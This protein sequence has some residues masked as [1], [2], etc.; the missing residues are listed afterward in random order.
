MVNYNNGKVYK[1]E[2]INGNDESIF[3]IGSTTKKYLSTRMAEHRAD[4]KRWKFNKHNKTSSFDVFEKYGVENCH[5]V[6]IEN[7]KCTSKDELLAREKY[8][9]KNLNC[10]NIVIPGTTIQERKKLYYET[11][12]D[13]ILEK[14][15]QYYK[16]NFEKI[17]DNKILKLIV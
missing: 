4:Y 12:K 8:Y 11:N 13:E 15:K 3:Y 6:L 9:I 1:I 16:N 2:S 10:N 7:V 14:Q 17:L 5:I